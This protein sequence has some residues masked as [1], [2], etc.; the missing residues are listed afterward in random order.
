MKP[1]TMLLAH[2]DAA[3]AA[4]RDLLAWVDALA[5]GIE[6]VQRGPRASDESPYQGAR[7]YLLLGEVRGFQTL[8]VQLFNDDFQLPYGERSLLSVATARH[9]CRTVPHKLYWAA[10]VYGLT[11]EG[12]KFKLEPRA[13]GF[14][15]RLEDVVAGVG[16]ESW[17]PM[18][19][20]EC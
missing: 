13:D 12:R 17:R 16:T 20:V 3:A 15:A 5:K 6:Q 4:F 2:D 14:M 18:K 7:M 19:E 9:L 10:R 11:P 1:S 8:L